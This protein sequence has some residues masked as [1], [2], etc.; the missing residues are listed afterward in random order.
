MVLAHGHQCSTVDPDDGIRNEALAS[1]HGDMC[2]NLAKSTFADAP[3]SGGDTSA[4]N[5]MLLAVSNTPG[6]YVQ[7]Q[8]LTTPT[9]S[10][11]SLLCCRKSCS[12]Q[13]ILIVVYVAST[14][15]Q[16]NGHLQALQS[17]EAA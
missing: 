6:T 1:S 16:A 13:D 10:L 9:V 11:V 17:T 15:I 8:T 12:D 2:F 4:V 3:F 7:Q 14:M 5:S